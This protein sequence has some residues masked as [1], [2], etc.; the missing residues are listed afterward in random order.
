M[1]DSF[2][3]KLT[4]AS[5]SCS[6]STTQTLYLIHPVVAAFSFSPGIVCQGNPVAFTNSSVG[7]GLTYEWLFGNGVT[8][9]S[10]NPVYTYANSGVYKVQLIATNSVPCHDTATGLV[11]V[12]STTGIGMRVSDTILCRATYVTLIG[13]YTSI[14]DTGV[15]WNFGNGDSIVNMNPV[16]Y[17]FDA[18]GSYWVTVTPHYRVC[19]DTSISRHITVLPSPQLYLGSDTSICPGSNGIIIGDNANTAAAGAAWKWNTGQT[20]PSISIVQ[21][22]RYYATVTVNG[23][24]ASDTITVNNDCYINIPN[25]FTPNGD[26]LNDYFFPREYLSRG[27]TAFRMEIYNRWGQLI[28]ETSSLDGAGWDGRFNNTEQP[29]GVYVYVIDTTFKDGQKNH[30]QGNVTLIR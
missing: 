25:V 3:V 29:V 7:T 21:P 16:H 13:D 30:R 5:G 1:Q 12:D 14:G 10:A 26:G 28:F 8:D 11:Y 18:T 4:V 17:A 27:L 6:D 23:C 2:K 22:G 9:N 20:T 24:A 19:R 15:T